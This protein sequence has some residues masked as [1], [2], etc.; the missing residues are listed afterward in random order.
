MGIVLNDL[1]CHHAW[2][3]RAGVHQPI[4]GDDNVRS[5][6]F[7][8]YMNLRQVSRKTQTIAFG[9]SQDQIECNGCGD[10]QI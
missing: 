5:E 10:G 3:E 9:S 2:S 7:S 8:V 4:L 1:F 6:V